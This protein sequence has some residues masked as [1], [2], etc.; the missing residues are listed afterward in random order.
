MMISSVKNVPLVL[1]KTWWDTY[2]QTES[3][4]ASVIAARK[5]ESYFG[6]ISNAK[7]FL[8]REGAIR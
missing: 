2:Q 5:I 4:E 1:A 6:S 8:Q 7:D 3:K